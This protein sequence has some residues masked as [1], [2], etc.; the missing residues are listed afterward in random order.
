MEIKRLDKVCVENGISKID[1]LCMDV[2]GYE[3]N[4]KKLNEKKS[5][6]KVTKK[7]IPAFS[8][9][10]QNVQKILDLHLAINLKRI[11]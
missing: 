2:Q 3:L 10:F 8:N 6:Y 5:Y 4:E 7:T 1:L 11:S 9:L